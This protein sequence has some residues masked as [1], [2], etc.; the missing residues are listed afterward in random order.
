MRGERHQLRPVLCDGLF[1][2]RI[3][4]LPLQLLIFPLSVYS[5]KP[6]NTNI[7]MDMDMGTGTGTG[8][9][10]GDQGSS[11][12]S[13]N[14]SMGMSMDMGMDPTCKVSTFVLVD[15]R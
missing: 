9:G 14:S 4:R 6:L 13:S 7:G 2:S 8:M 12:N 1:S 15:L 5:N 11:S 10:M 3:L